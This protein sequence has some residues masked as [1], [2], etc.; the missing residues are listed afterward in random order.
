MLPG[1]SWLLVSEGL[2]AVCYNKFVFLEIRW[3]LEK[4]SV[5]P[6]RLYVTWKK[7]M[8]ELIR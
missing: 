7:E 3:W 2:C 6:R 1:Y 4:K 8:P 5:R